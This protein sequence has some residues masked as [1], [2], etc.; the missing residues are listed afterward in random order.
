MKLYQIICIMPLAA[1]AYANGADNK[2][3]S[4]SEVAESASSES[5]ERKETLPFGLSSSMTIDQIKGKLKEKPFL[6]YRSTND[7]KFKSGAAVKVLR[8]H[9]NSLD[10]NGTSI[11]SLVINYYKNKIFSVRLHSHNTDEPSQG[12]QN[13]VN[14][15]EFLVT[16]GYEVITNDIDEIT[17]GGDLYRNTAVF[18]LQISENDGVLVNIFSNEVETPGYQVY[19]HIE[20]RVL[21]TSAEKERDE[22]EAMM[23]KNADS[24]NKLK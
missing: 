12:K 7:T 1:M 17:T 18:Q 23:K 4:S 16:D 8:Y 5:S 24:A 13:L 3:P 20:Y 14:L 11:E 19:Q 10:L 6:S 21:A 2:Q 15:A 9:V 22:D